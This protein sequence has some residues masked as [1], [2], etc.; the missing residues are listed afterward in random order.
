RQTTRKWKISAAGLR[1]ALQFSATECGQAVSDDSF[2]RGNAF[3]RIRTLPA[4]DHD[5]REIWP[6]WR[7]PCP[8]R[9]RGSAVANAPKLGL[10]QEGARYF[11]RRLSRSVQENSGGHHSKDERRK[12]SDRR[13]FLS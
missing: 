6:V 13:C 9:F 10:G 3:P 11:C 1:V 12:E 8:G 7:H 5:P 4:R 2:R